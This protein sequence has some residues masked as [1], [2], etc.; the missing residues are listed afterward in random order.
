VPKILP[1]R[2]GKSVSPKHILQLKIR[3]FSKRDISPPKGLK[4]FIFSSFF[5]HLFSSLFY[6]N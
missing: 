4:T 1:P 6:K 5:A 2:G 3:L